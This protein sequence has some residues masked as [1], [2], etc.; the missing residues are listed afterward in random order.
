MK[1]SGV[2][3]LTQ[4]PLDSDCWGS[5]ELPLYVPC[6][7]CPL[8]WRS[9]KWQSCTHPS[10]CVLGQ[11]CVCVWLTINGLRVEG[12]CRVQRQTVHCH[13][14]A[15]DAVP[16][17]SQRGCAVKLVM[18]TCPGA[19]IHTNQDIIQGPLGR[20]FAYKDGEK[21]VRKTHIKVVVLLLCSTLS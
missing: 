7:Q 1:Q 12:K 19:V 6:A 15:L 4:G 3:C 20:V 18:K 11:W 16:V 10:V 9:Y 8:Q 5:V 21:E 2:K 13:L 17:V 14:S